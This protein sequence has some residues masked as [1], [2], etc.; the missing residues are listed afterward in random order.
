MVGYRDQRSPN[1]G[2]GGTR[3]TGLTMGGSV[4]KQF[5]YDSHVTLYL[6]RSTPVSAFEDN[7]F[8]V[9]TS[10]QATGRFPLPLELQLQ[11]GLGY[12]WNDYRT[13]SLETG[14][15]RK[16]DIFGYELGLRRALHR[17]FFLSAAYRR[18]ERRSNLERFDTDSDGFYLQLEWNFL[19]QTP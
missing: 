12:Q 14:E 11:G 9:H 17:R 15:P 2:A 7:A 13:L 5:G 8:Y 18:E 3:Y 6:N 4:T 10:L 16:D 19:G 1:G